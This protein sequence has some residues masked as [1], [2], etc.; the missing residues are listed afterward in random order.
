MA[1]EIEKLNAITLANIA[2]FNTFADSAIEKINGLEFTGVTLFKGIFGFGTNASEATVG[3]TNLVSNVG[4]VATDTSAVGTA[5]THGA[6]AEYGT[7][8][9]IFGFGQTDTSGDSKTGITNLV[10]TSGVVASDV[11]AVGTARQALAAAGYGTDKAIFGFGTTGDY[12]VDE[13]VTGIT[14]LVNN[15]GVVQS[16]TSAVGTARHQLQAETYDDDK[17][18]FMYGWASWP[19]FLSTKNLV[20]NS[21]VVASDASATGTSRR[22]GGTAGYGTGTAIIAFGANASGNMSTSNLINTS[23]V[24]SSD[25][26]GVGTAR[27]GLAGCQYGSDKG[28][29]GFGRNGSRY[30]I[31]NL[32]SNAGVVATDTSGVGTARDTP[33]AAS[34]GT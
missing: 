2:K 28:I 1:N 19:T 16:D 26:T 9:A 20:N 32:V 21:G 4:V 23:G 8:T 24:I 10:N 25:V 34:Y 5:R 3:V 30:S 6:A 22:W 27:N 12:G 14:N 29:L 11:S 17:A 18:I 13:A 7:G 15:S 33:M 31:T